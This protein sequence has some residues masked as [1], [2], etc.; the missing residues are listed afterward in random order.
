VNDRRFQTGDPH[1]NPAFN[2]TRFVE[3]DALDRP[4]WT[5][6]YGDSD[7]PFRLANLNAQR[8]TGHM[9]ALPDSVDI[10]SGRP[11]DQHPSHTEMGE[12]LDKN[13][14]E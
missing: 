13:R 14:A 3:Y 2:L 9:S 11:R 10:E 4:V 7:A 12:G 5:S 1:P 8:R 6:V